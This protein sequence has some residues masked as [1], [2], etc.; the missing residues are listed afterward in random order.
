MAAGTPKSDAQLAID[1]D[2]VVFQNA[3]NLI[4]G[5][6]DNQLRQDVLVSKINKDKMGVAGA[7]GVAN[8]D[9]TQTALGTKADNSGAT[10]TSATVNGV[11]LSVAAG[12]TVFLAGDGTYK[13]VPVVAEWGNITGTLGSQ[14]DLSNALAGKEAAFAKNTAFNKDFG[15]GAG[16]VPDAGLVFSAINQKEDAFPKNSAFNKN[17]GAAAGTVLEG[18][19]LAGYINQAAILDLIRSDLSNFDATTYSTTSNSDTPAGAAFVTTSF[20]N[21][22]VLEVVVDYK[23][24]EVNGT[25]QAQEH[26]SRFYIDG[27]AVG[28]NAIADAGNDS[29]DS[30][31]GRH[32]VKHTKVGDGTLSL[33]LQHRRNQNNG[34][35]YTSGII[36]SVR[37]VNP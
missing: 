4:T 13:T 15:V 33:Q 16:Q 27:V 18:D 9:A 24:A 25:F 26:R 14:T 20:K 6:N 11:T 22:D 5:G 34:T 37:K 2:A 23:Y 30:V 7:E 31:P 17:F 12:T 10:L 1:T 28:S 36:Y 21:G 29:N 35:I 3:S 19:S 32:M 8:H